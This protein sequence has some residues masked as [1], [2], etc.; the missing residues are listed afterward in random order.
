MGNDKIVTCNLLRF[1]ALLIDKY[2]VHELK[3]I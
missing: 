2:I 3:I 1:E